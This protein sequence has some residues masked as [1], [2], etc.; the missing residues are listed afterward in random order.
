MEEKRF[1]IVDDTQLEKMMEKS[2]AASTDKAT[3][4][5]VKLIK[6]FCEESGILE[7]KQIEN[8]SAIELLPALQRFYAGARNEKGE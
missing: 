7:G 1:A 8:L 5:A 2:M 6:S 4:F 3:T